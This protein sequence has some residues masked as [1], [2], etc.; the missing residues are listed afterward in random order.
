MIHCIAGYFGSCWGEKMADPEFIEAMIDDWLWTSFCLFTI[1]GDL[2]F[3]NLESPFVI[4][5]VLG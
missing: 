3:G 5:S 4:T 1:I 2:F